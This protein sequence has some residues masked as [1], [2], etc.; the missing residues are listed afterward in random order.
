MRLGGVDVPLRGVAAVACVPELRRRGVADRVMKELLRRM[1][2]QGDALALLYP[3]SVPF[4]RKFGFGTCE[5]IDHVRVRPGQLPASRLRQHVRRY[6]EARDTPAMLRVYDAA[7]ADTTGP[8][9][10]SDWWW[11]YRVMR[12]AP[13]RVVYDDPAARKL[14]GYLLYDVPAEPA[15]PKQRCV[16]RELCAT[17]PDAFR[18]LLGY[19]EALGEQFAVIELDLPRG[20]AAAMLGDTGL[21][22]APALPILEASSYT[23]AGAMARVVDVPLALALHPG[24]ERAEAR[25]RMGLDLNDPVFSAQSRPFDVT[26]AA[27]GVRVDPG[28]ACRDRL[29]LS[30]DRFSQI[31]FA[32][33]S[34]RVLHAQGLVTGSPRAA[35]LLDTALAGPPAF[36]MRGNFF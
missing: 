13:D 2:R 21:D 22:G 7:R 24:P 6:D 5:W 27:R 9:A 11:A 16:V 10:R 20:H 33:A 25:G 18:G 26:F 14:T 23:L 29:A 35:A 1:H 17:T 3:F 31:Y 15:Y 28:R 4:Y 34:A 12:R 8:L 32:G 36:L 19:L 30:I